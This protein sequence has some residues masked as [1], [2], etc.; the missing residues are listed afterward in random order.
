[1]LLKGL[2]HTLWKTEVMLSIL[3]W[4]FLLGCFNLAATLQGGGYVGGCLGGGVPAWAVQ[5]DARDG[6]CLVDQQLRSAK[7]R[8]SGPKES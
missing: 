8:D 1:V 7:Q 4:L 6:P 5:G 3:L 2:T